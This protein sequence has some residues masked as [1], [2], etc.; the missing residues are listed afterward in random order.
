MPTSR[1]V[2]ARAL[3]RGGLVGSV[4]LLASGNGFLQLVLVLSAPISSRLYS[5]EDYGALAVF[6]AALAIFSYVVC[7]RYDLA[8]PMAED[9]RTAVFLV[10]L[11]MLVT[12]GVS[13]VSGIVLWLWGAEIVNLLDADTLK[14]YL[15]L[16]PLGLIALGVYHPLAY[17]SVRTK[18]YEALAKSRVA[19][20][21]SSVA[22]NLGVGAVHEGPLGLLLSNVALSSSGIGT[23]WRVARD[24]VR[25]NLHQV[26][27]SALWRV[28]RDYKQFPLLSAPAGMINTL[29]LMLCPFLLSAFYGPRVAGWF[30]LA[31][32]TMNMPTGLI[33]GA[34][35]QVWLGEAADTARNAPKLLVR[36]FD[37][38]SSRLTLL[39]LLVLA[40]GMTAPFVFGFVFGVAWQRAGLFAALVTP[41]Y[42]S[43]LVVIPVSTT[44]V[45]AKRQDLQFGIDLARCALVALSLTMPYKMGLSPEW[46]VGAYG[47]G[48]LAMNLATFALYRRL[49]RTTQSRTSDC[50]LQPT[51][52]TVGTNDREG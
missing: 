5:P 40:A 47:L 18:S 36:R 42:A 38:L 12:L 33:G 51:S 35:Y 39:A 1:E 13:A 24:S 52:A 30:A 49:V 23:L 19:Q 15:W 27:A 46:A 14:S 4:A 41:F 7:G 34:I 10:L 21:V 8:V 45:I 9:D 31:Q 6:G 22:L 44:A 28:A 2:L 29:A 3:A 26:S 11:G 37:R 16:L 43:Q 50:D 48:M 32:R 20:G 25:R 17:W